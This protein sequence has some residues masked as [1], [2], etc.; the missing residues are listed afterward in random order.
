MTLF[1]KSIERK[2][3][4]KYFC[5]VTPSLG[6]T[7]I[8]WVV[9]VGI[10]IDLKEGWRDS[11]NTNEGTKGGGQKKLSSVTYKI[12]VG[13]HRRSQTY[14]KLNPFTELRTGVEDEEKVVNK[15]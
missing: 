9:G 14:T 4:I 5:V 3:L 10:I 13:N 6:L 15:R 11:S 12:G 2:I 8:V 7:H 1:K